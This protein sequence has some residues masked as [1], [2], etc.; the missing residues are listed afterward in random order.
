MGRISIVRGSRVALI[1]AS[2]GV[3]AAAVSAVASSTVR[4]AW[5]HNEVIAYKCADSLCLTEPRVG[6]QRRLLVSRL[7]WPQ[8]DPAFSPD[9]REVAFRGYYQPGADGAYAL[10]LTQTNGCTAKRLT[11]GVAGDPAWSPDGRWIVYDTSGYGDIYKVHPDGSGRT[12]L[13]AGHGIDEG[14]FPAWSP[15]GGWIAFVRTRRHGSQIWL[16]RPDGGDKRLL[17]SDPTAVDQS[18]AW[19]HSGRR[20]TFGRSTGVNRGTIAVMRA[21][22]TGLRTLTADG[23]AW[24]PI[25][26]PG[27]VGIGYLAGIRNSNGTVSAGHLYVMRP[28]GTEKHPA[29]GPRTIQFA[30]TTGGGSTLERCR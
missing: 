2:T 25:W 28:D 11:R 19:S 22:G 20:L 12:R 1:L 27:D 4:P 7:P 23:A 8:W 14:W 15:D 30:S 21:D 6:V 26:L 13:F 5:P 9:G 18:L 16:M 17:R 29:A 24:N 3:F 10:Y